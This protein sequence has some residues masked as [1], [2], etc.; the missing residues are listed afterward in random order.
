MAI[1]LT[2]PAMKGSCQCGQVR[3]EINGKPLGLGFCYC[4]E[5]QKMSTGIGTY[6][7]MVP[8][9]AFNKLCGSLKTWER[10]AD[11]GN[12]NVGHFCPD[13]GVRIYHEN[14][15]VDYIRLKAGTLD[16]ARDLIPHAIAYLKRKPKWVP[17]A[18]SIL[19]FDGMP[20]IEKVIKSL[21]QRSEV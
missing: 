5:C 3:Y 14:P 20:D 11:S 15:E 12:R 7:M 18:E 10:L 13:C 8:R 1:D 17:M 4:S 21:N 6:S 19:G 16:N 9:A 2:E